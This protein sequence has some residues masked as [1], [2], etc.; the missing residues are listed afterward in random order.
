[1]GRLENSYIIKVL[2]STFKPK[3]V[4]NIP[5][6]TE[7]FLSYFKGHK[8]L[9]TI[10]QPNSQG[11]QIPANYP[12]PDDHDFSLIGISNK[13]GHDVYFTV[14]E[15]NHL[16]RK[17][18]NIESIRAIFADDDNLIASPRTDWKLEPSLIVQTSKKGVLSKYHYY[19]L[20]ST[21]DVDEWERV[22]EGI[23]KWYKTDPAVKDLARIL[24]V[25]GYHNCK[26]KEKSLCQVVGGTG[27]TYS[28]KNIIEKFPPVSKSE[29]IKTNPIKA[30]E[31][32][33]EQALVEV[34]LSGEHISD[35]L[36]SLI[37]HWAHHYSTTNILKKVEQLHEIIKPE[38][39]QEHGDRYFAA[40]SQAKK[41]TRSAKNKINKK[42]LQENTQKVLNTPIKAQSLTGRDKA[43][44]SP[45]PKDSVPECVYT[46]A[47]ELGRYLANGTEP[48]II[49]AMS[50]AC[51][52]LSKNVLIHEMGDTTTTY[53][54]TGIIVAMET[55][56][57][58]TQIYKHLSKPFIEFEKQLQD[59]WQINKNPIE[60]ALST[61][62]DMKKNF[63]AERS[64]LIKKGAT[65]N[66]LKEINKKIS[67]TMNEMDSL[68]LHKPTLHIKDITEEEV[69]VKMGQNQGSMAVISDDSRNIIKNILGRYGTNNTAEGWVIDGMG[70]TDIRY[71][72]AKNMGTEIII[73]DP[74][75]N[76]YL[77]VQ[78]DMAIKFKEH[79]VYKE[80]GLA[81]RVPVYFYPID[82][83]KMV[84]DSNRQNVLDQ[85]KLAEY[86]NAFK[87]I[88][89]RRIDNPLIVKVSDKANER[90]NKFNLRFL[91]LLKGEWKGEYRKT[92]KLITQAVILG[93][94]M[95]SLDDRK[96]REALNS[97]PKE[98]IEYILT[99]K[100]ANMG[101]N[102]IEAI[103]DGMLK[104]TESLDNMHIAD[105]A[106]RFAKS[107]IK[108]YDEG[109]IT[110][111]FVNT[112]Y[113]QNSFS[114]I[115][116]D[117]RLEVIELMVSKGW[118]KTVESTEVRGLNKG[119]PGGKATPGEF[120]YHLNI[121]EVK[122]LL[123]IK[124]LYK[125]AEVAAS[126]QD[127]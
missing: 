16:G 51:A 38:I 86:Y 31:D 93:T 124:T 11:D 85:T 36:N 48:S 113:L 47:T 78:P 80:S 81:A 45:I 34:F 19:W 76:M 28:W 68:Q 17:A 107:L 54:S 7:K 52:A 119:F 55:G 44:I 110:E 25:P 21:E 125:N 98:G 14:N 50:L 37:A 127:Q 3:M 66:E 13:N 114:M 116:K 109:R 101:C 69:V 102:Y 103:Y 1:M 121:S 90:F 79:E 104:S 49:A 95:A 64:K 89:V 27:K 106:E 115:T 65:F 33:N 72:R 46:A 96:F 24:R 112:S 56:T 4:T 23:V 71:N 40:V 70:G 122:Q 97:D 5:D 117:N 58:K 57:R 82:P 12:D 60:S 9:V 10:G 35:P 83:L 87:G 118:L 67:D 39:K 22:M 15:T 88:C 73:E 120:I 8:T 108:H 105:T 26:Y 63:E 77:M 20:T 30:G 123:N 92:N 18:N 59:E 29:R 62:Q 91:E 6:H 111:G 41:W 32:F 84:H 53:C 94:V 42:R 74:C 100:Y 99:A 61:L 75:L 2:M 43:D 126:E